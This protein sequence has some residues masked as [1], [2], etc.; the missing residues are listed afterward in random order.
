MKGLQSCRTD[1]GDLSL[2][3]SEV[4]LSNIGS[5]RVQGSDRPIDINVG[6]RDLFMVDEVAAAHTC[7]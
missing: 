4:P 3:F 7:T 6:S 2:E 1:L 5:G